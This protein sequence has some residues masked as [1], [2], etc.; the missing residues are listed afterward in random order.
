MPV[1]R[2]PAAPANVHEFISSGAPDQSPLHQSEQVA[3][4]PVK[5]RVPQ[6]LLTQIDAAVASRRPAPSRHQWIIEAIYQKLERDSV[7]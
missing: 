6:D 7:L 1:R 2:K 3:A 5:L 4:Q